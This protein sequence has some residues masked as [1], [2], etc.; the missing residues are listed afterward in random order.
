MAD[1]TWNLQISQAEDHIRNQL[2]CHM[3]LLNSDPMLRAISDRIVSSAAKARLDAGYAGS[4]GDGGATE[5]VTKFLIFLDGYSYA[6]GFKA[7]CY[8][9]I[10][11]QIEKEKDLE[12]QKY[13]ELKKKFE[14]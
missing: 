1:N 8:Q 11:D 6:K 9:S 14:S 13:L 4:M 3:N 10:I 2:V 7:G 5:K 12:Y